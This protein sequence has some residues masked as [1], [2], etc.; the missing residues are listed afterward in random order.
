[1]QACDGIPESSERVGHDSLSN[2]GGTVGTGDLTAL[3][4]SLSVDHEDLWYFDPFFLLPAV[5]CKPCSAACA[6]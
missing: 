6:A 1:M 4:R 2:V 5:L 3:L